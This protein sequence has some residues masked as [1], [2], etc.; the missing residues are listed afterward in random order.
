MFIDGINTGMNGLG[1]GG[2]F[3]FQPMSLCSISGGGMGGGGGG[4]I[5]QRPTQ[6]LVLQQVM[7]VAPRLEMQ[8]RMGDRFYDAVDYWTRS[9]HRH[10]TFNVGGQ[11]HIVHFTFAPP[12]WMEAMVPGEKYGFYFGDMMFLNSD[13]IKTHPEWAPFVV[14]KL[15]GERFME[16]GLDPTGMHKH[17]EALFR[18][19]RLANR[20]MDTDQLRAFLEELRR[21]ER[22][23]YFNWDDEARRFLDGGGDILSAKQAYLERH[24][25]NAWVRRGRQWEAIAELDPRLVGGFRNIGEAVCRRLA[26]ENNLLYSA[27]LFVREMLSVT[28]ETR[29][30]PGQLVVVS[31]LEMNRVAYLL[32]REANGIADLVRFVADHGLTVGKRDN[33]VVKIGGKYRASWV[34]LSKRLSFE[35]M[36]LEGKVRELTAGHSGKLEGLVVNL[37]QLNDAATEEITRARALLA[38]GASTSSDDATQAAKALAVIGQDYPTA[39]A[40]L[41]KEA[42]RVA[43]N[44]A[45]L[46]ALA[47][48]LA[49]LI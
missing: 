7:T 43:Q 1:L 23:G 5:I 14:V 10:V 17:Y 25:D 15:Y 27:A 26:G 39:A 30:S 32:T 22:S 11:Q 33:V 38:A 24:H 2:T 44:L 36:R 34:A 20:V 16:D 13:L 45:E 21:H 47:D 28:P 49:K 18:T 19:I 12:Q 35:I 4:G 8:V 48:E 31:G 41:Q 42:A 6:M 40:E 3:T 46:R 29:T 37:R 9:E